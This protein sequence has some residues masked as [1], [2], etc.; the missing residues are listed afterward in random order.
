MVA[1]GYHYIRFRLTN[2]MT[3]FA[4]EAMKPSETE[5]ITITLI[6]VVFA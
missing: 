3:I 2:D 4:T 1:N 6:T 5:S